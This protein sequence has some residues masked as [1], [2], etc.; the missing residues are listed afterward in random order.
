MSTIAFDFFVPVER[1]DFKP[2]SKT[3]NLRGSLCY[4]SFEEAKEDFQKSADP[5]EYVIQHIRVHL[6]KN[7]VREMVAAEIFSG[8]CFDISS[9]KNIPGEII[10]THEVIIS[11]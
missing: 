11:E 4:D 5:G 2:G 1:Q 7:L 3:F 10:E 8:V 9:G 6:D